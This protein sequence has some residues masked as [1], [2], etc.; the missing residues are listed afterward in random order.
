LE[1]ERNLV[2]LQDRNETYEEKTKRIQELKKKIQELEKFK[3]VLNYKIKELKRE[4][5]PSSIQILKLNEQV[6]K[7]KSELKH[8]DRVNKN[9]VL[10]VDDMR[11]RQDGLK[12]ELSKM[13]QRM[14]EQEA[15]RRRVGDNVVDVFT[16]GIG[17]FKKLKRSV[18]RLYRS[19]V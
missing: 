11:M 8:F 18:V 4:I 3:F 5:G 9:L 2:E 6:S 1:N 14:K 10:I 13:T 17:D 15:D 16:H 19:W 12:K 7:M